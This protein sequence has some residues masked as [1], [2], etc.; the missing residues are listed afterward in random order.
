[1]ISRRSAVLSLAALGA[2]AAGGVAT[3]SVAARRRARAEAA[4]PPGGQF[5]EVGGRKIHAYV[6][7]NGPDLV[8]L[9]GAFG[10]ARDF[11]FD[12]V[13][14]L[15]PH[16]RVIAFDRPGMGYSDHIAPRFAGPAAPRAETPAEQAGVLTQAARQLGAEKPIVLGLS[17]IHI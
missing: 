10:S 5:V 7:G 6:T 16:Y 8:L 15:E 4:T 17:L 9:H 12:L 14:R 11:T 13:R 3:S 2:L 1:M